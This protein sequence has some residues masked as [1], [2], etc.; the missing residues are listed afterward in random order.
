LEQKAMS[1]LSRHQ[2]D[3]STGYQLHDLPGAHLVPRRFVSDQPRLNEVLR[4]L[5]DEWL[6]YAMIRG[7]NRLSD[8]CLND[9]GIKRK[10]IRPIVNA[11]IRCIRKRRTGRQQYPIFTLSRMAAGASPGWTLTGLS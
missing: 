9:I 7:L 10:D 1:N 2:L 6:R 11:I 8:D 4:W 3:K 5:Q